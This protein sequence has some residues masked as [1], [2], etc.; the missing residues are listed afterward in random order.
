MLTLPANARDHARTAP[1]AFLRPPILRR[2]DHAAKINFRWDALAAEMDLLPSIFFTT[3][4]SLKF[5]SHGV[6][7]AIIFSKKKRAPSSDNGRRS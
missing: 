2:G 4:K 5:T 1:Q 6:G 3:I 7:L